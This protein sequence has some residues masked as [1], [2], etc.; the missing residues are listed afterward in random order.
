MQ[1]ER[2]RIQVPSE[3][4]PIQLRVPYDKVSRFANAVRLDGPSG[5]TYR[6]YQ[7]ALSFA[8]ED[9]KYVAQVAR[10]LRGMNLRIFYDDYETVDLWGK[11][12]YV[13]L[14]DVYRKKAQYCVLFLSEHYARKLWTN[15]ERESAQAR[16]FE[17]HTEYVLPVKLDNTEVPGLRP[18]TGYLGRLAPKK[19]AEAIRSKVRAYRAS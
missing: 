12:L 18:T 14:D 17:E 10:H 1:S 13:H 5:A 2:F 16:A 11:D 9:R 19:L 15:H 6:E 8:G 7:V 3:R 4:G